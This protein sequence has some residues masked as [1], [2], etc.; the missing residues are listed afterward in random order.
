MYLLES[1]KRG[2]VSMSGQDQP[3]IPLAT[4]SA[5]E[6]S[7]TG[8]VTGPAAY[9]RQEAT[10]AEEGWLPSSA[11]RVHYTCITTTWGKQVHDAMTHRR[12]VSTSHSTRIGKTRDRTEAYIYTLG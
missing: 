10:R 12:R 7:C 6:L 2:L 8:F 1:S 5:V 9:V 4:G 3:P 11:V